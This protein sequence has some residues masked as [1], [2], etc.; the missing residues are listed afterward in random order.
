MKN[1]N[2]YQLSRDYFN[3]AFEHP[4]ENNPTMTALYFFLVEVNNRLGWKRE[5]GIT[6]RECMEATGIGSYNTYKKN[7]DLLVS[8]GF[9]NLV[10]RSANQYQTNIIALSNFDKANNKA[11]D[12]ALSNSDKADEKHVTNHLRHSKTINK[13][14]INT[15]VESDDSTSKL[16]F[17]NAWNLYE[18]KGNK[19]TSCQRWNKLSDKNRELA[20]TNIPL[21]VKSTP[22]KQF[23]K[24][25]QAYINQEVWNDE[26]VVNE[27]SEQKVDTK[28]EGLTRIVGL[29][30]G[31]TSR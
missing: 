16:S 6:A 11:L 3:W 29:G 30:E 12:F 8:N 2:G 19:K 14:T 5:F 21:Y 20:L 10:R 9:I 4:S 28:F 25:F 18:K 31:I 22:D 26:I 7:F 17:E 27:Q 13:E 1:I 24:D 23:R 15:I